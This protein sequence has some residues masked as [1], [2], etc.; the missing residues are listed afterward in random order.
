MPASAK[1]NLATLAL[2]ATDLNAA[3]TRG[4]IGDITPQRLGSSTATEAVFEAIVPPHTGTAYTDRTFVFTVEGEVYTHPL[5][6]TFDFASDKA[7]G[8][9][10]TL[11]ERG[12]PLDMSDDDGL[13]NCYMVVPGTTSVAISIERAVTVGGMNASAT[14]VSLVELWDD[15]NVIDENNGISALSGDGASRTFTVT[16]TANEG[17]AG[18]ALKGSDG[19][20]YWSWHIWVTNYTGST[21]HPGNGCTFMDRNLGA[22]AATATLAG[23]GLFYQWGRKDPF[24]GGKTGTAGYKEI[25]KFSGLGSSITVNSQNT[26]D[27]GIRIGIMESIQR[28]MTF[29]SRRNTT[30]NNWLPNNNDRIWNASANKKTVYDPCPKGWRLPN[31]IMVATNGDIGYFACPFG[32]MT[33]RTSSWTDLNTD[34]ARALINNDDNPDTL[35]PL[36]G[37]IKD[38]GTYDKVG[39]AFIQWYVGEN[40]ACQ[41]RWGFPGYY[42][43]DGNRWMQYTDLYGTT[44][45]A[46]EALL[47]FRGGNM[48][49][50]AN[51]RCAK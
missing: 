29:F 5:P 33:M 42:K 49:D 43:A 44:T 18:I 37:F 17:N 48:L 30:Y 14:N 26:T 6:N 36:A 19:T 7:Y 41:N 34:N 35:F 39:R 13:A 23:R 10:L 51:V 22:T 32:W 3:I 11:Q 9:V 45:A 8:F 50:G 12:A 46:S 28:P 31:Y 47:S 21:T 20:I 38:G 25:N 2:N 16:A 40:G 4:T 15:N 24:P 27:T 1:V